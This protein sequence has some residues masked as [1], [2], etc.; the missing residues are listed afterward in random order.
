M[1][2]NRPALDNSL[3]TRSQAAFTPR[4]PTITG[5]Q[6]PTCVCVACP[7]LF[8]STSPRISSKRTLANERAARSSRWLVDWRARVLTLP[9][10]CALCV[11]V[12]RP[13]VPLSLSLVS[14]GQC[15]QAFLYMRRRRPWTLCVCI[16][17]LPLWTNAVNCVIRR[18]KQVHE[19]R[20]PEKQFSKVRTAPL[21]DK[22]TSTVCEIRRK[23]WRTLCC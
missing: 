11:H 21:S 15:V 5:V 22:Q 8:F 17:A 14:S 20:S 18:D 2:K 1:K 23:W 9:R 4:Q 16:Y 6:P 10:V 13:R 7:S 3:F 19:P 12:T